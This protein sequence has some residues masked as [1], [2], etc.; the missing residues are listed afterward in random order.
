[1]TS[2][3]KFDLGDRVTWAE[4]E[5]GVHVELTVSGITSEFVGRPGSDVVHKYSLWYDDGSQ[6]GGWVHGIM[7]DDIAY[8]GWY[9][10]VEG[11]APKDDE[12]WLLSLPVGTI[13]RHESNPRIT[14]FIYRSSGRRF[15]VGSNWDSGP[16]SVTDFPNNLGHEYRVV[17]FGSGV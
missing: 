15:I 16:V 1:M 3:P 9:G 12:A 5:G 11:D 4:V 7:Q 8:R 14:A 17:S 13:F 10:V 2:K 6:T